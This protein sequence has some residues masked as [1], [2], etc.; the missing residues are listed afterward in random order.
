V[1]QKG[2]LSDSCT[3]F[4]DDAVIGSQVLSGKDKTLELLLRGKPYEG[5]NKL[6][7]NLDRTYTSLGC[8]H[9]DYRTQFLLLRMRVCCR[10][11]G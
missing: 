10:G 9:F 6:Y 8:R 3:Q 5:Q 1:F 4:S 11:A 7:S 2:L